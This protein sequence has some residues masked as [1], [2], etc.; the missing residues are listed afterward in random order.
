MRLPDGNSAFPTYRRLGVQVL[1]LDL[2]WADSA[3]RR[4]AH[5]EDPADPA[6]RWPASVTEAARDAGR[7]GI[8]LCLLVQR[9]PA[10]SNGNRPPV[11]AP[12][13][14]GDYADFLV[15]ASR[16]YPNVRLWMIWG[17]PNRNLLPDFEPMP[18][19][20]PVGP[21]RYAVLL[22]AAYEALKRAARSNTVIG[23]DTGSFGTVEPADF[24]RWMRLPDGRPPELDL[25]GHNPYSRR[26]PDLREPPYF[27][28]GRDINDIDT[29]ESQLT[30]TYHR[31]VRLWLSEF[32]ISSDHNNVAF[33]FHVSRAQ[34]A[35]WLRA[36]YSLAGSV[37]YVAGLGWFNL[38]DDPPSSAEHLSDGL[39]SSNLKPKPA[40]FAYQQVR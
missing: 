4:P 16:R 12:N 1:Q 8:D 34:Q 14:A 5:P 7:Y 10:W 26:F 3:P 13:D 6:Y 23:G 19:N 33:D 27:R 20:S 35:R 18:P 31:P 38:I 9:S 32:T 24:L 40:F 15:A 17:E 36:A 11:W 39:M 37:P 22:Q 30:G 29:L 2:S 28:G 25:Y 21:R